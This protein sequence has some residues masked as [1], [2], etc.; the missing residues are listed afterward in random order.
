MQSGWRT[1]DDIRE[2]AE[3]GKSRV[4]KTDRGE[5]SGVRPSDSS[6]KTGSEYGVQIATETQIA[7][8]AGARHLNS[9]TSVPSRSIKNFE[10]KDAEETEKGKAPAELACSCPLAPALWG[11]GQGEGFSFA[12]GRWVTLRQIVRAMRASN[13]SPQLCGERVRVRGFS[14]ASGRWVTRR[15]IV[16]AM[17][18]SNPSP[19]PCGE[20]VRV[21]GFL[22]RK[23]WDTN[24]P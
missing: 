17:R 19:Q 7:I 10:Q 3:R 18:A 8:K 22:K 11:E 5:P 6:E 14:F 21:K 20:R 24:L 12:S 23:L 9:V 1:D 16:R 4:D 13:P 15:Q 2:R